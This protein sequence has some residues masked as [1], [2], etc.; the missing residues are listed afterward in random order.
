MGRFKKLFS[1][2]DERQNFKNREIEDLIYLKTLCDLM[3]SLLVLKCLTEEMKKIGMNYIL[4]DE[5]AQNPES[6]T[7]N[8]PPCEAEYCQSPYAPIF[9]SPPSYDE[10]MRNSKPS[11]HVHS[12]GFSSIYPVQQQVLVGV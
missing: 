11:T 9:L 7:P 1:K 2:K 10:A 12:S 5:M 8:A 3:L 4:R 6:L